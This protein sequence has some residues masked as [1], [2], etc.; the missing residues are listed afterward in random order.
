MS[1]IKDFEL[2][3]RIHVAT[4]QLKTRI[5]ELEAERDALQA[6]VDAC[7]ELYEREA[8]TRAE[9]DEFQRLLGKATSEREEMRALAETWKEKAHKWAENGDQNVA[10]WTKACREAEAERDALRKLLEEA[11]GFLAGEGI[12]PNI[13]GRIDALAKGKR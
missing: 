13:V 4:H 2:A 6:T 12:Y 8:A 7:G 11:R 10:G 5:A 3:Q 1:G 9:R